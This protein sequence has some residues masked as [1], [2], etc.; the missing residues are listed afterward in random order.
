MNAATVRRSGSV[1]AGCP[2]PRDAREGAKARPGPGPSTLSMV[3]R[4][5]AGSRARLVQ[6]TLARAG[7]SE[8]WRQL[9]ADVPGQAVCDRGLES[10]E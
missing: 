6:G 7:S 5:L 8:E 3:T 9:V 4:A 2:R 10:E 1:E